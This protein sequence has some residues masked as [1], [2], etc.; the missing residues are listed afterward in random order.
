MIL[1]VSRRTDIPAFYSEWFMNRI[2]EGFVFVRNPLYPNKISKV[3]ITPDVV[4]CIVFWSKNPKPLLPRLPELDSLEYKYYFQWTITA[5]REDV[6]PGVGNK[7]EIIQMILDLSARIGKE[8]IILRYDPIL[9]TDSYSEEYHYK[10]FE[11]LCGTVKEATNKIIISFVDDYRKNSRN[12]KELNI[13]PLKHEDM[14]RIAK[15]LAAIASRYNLVVETCAE[16]IDLDDIG[17]KHGHCIDGDLIEKIIGHPI[18]NKDKKDGNREYCG[19]MKSIDIGQ[20][21]SCIFNCA[22]C[23]ANV[24]AEIAYRNY[25]SH[26]PNSPILIGEY[27]DENVTD[28]KDVKSWKKDLGKIGEQVTVE[29]ILGGKE[30]LI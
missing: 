19:C 22:Y 26:D 30:R 6:E 21:D 13:I 16:Q 18:M 10:A 3:E 7:E 9:I 1:S 29:E 4:D 2:A 15:E 24:N 5:Y 20:Y 8:R 11:R 27:E 25:L 23:Y 14:L 28:R 12:L 17:I